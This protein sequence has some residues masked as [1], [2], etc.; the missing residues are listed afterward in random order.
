MKHIFHK[1]NQYKVFVNLLVSLSKKIFPV[2]STYLE[3]L[4]HVVV[5][6]ITILVPV[7]IINLY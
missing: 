7:V 3:T 5:I 6:T 1:K 4:K 2:K